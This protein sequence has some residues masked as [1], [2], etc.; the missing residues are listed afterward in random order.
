MSIAISIAMDS[1]V[2]MSSECSLD[3]PSL[4]GPS[5]VVE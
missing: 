2:K 4:A 1:I 5:D 3:D